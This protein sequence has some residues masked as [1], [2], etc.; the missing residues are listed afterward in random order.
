MSILQL[1]MYMKEIEYEGII[2]V[3]IWRFY[4]ILRLKMYKRRIFYERSLESPVYLSY[5]ISFH[6]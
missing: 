4:I 2:K 1:I 6:V 3:K 5:L